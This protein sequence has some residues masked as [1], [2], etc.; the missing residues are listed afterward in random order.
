MPMTKK[1]E[2]I[3]SSM[4]KEYGKDKGKQ[5]F[6]A[7]KNKGIISGVDKAREKTHNE[8]CKSGCIK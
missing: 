8:M 2:K 7:S 5:V 6:Y 1:G 3:M 4:K